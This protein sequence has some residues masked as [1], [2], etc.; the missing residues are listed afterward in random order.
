MGIYGI[1]AKYG[2]VREKKDEFLQNQCACIGW[3]VEQ[4]P[5]L[6]KMLQKIKIGDIIYI[7][8]M[9]GTTEKELIIKAIGVVTDDTIVERQGLGLGISVR[10]IWVGEKRTS[11]TEEMYKNN[12]FNNTLYEEFNPSVSSLILETLFPR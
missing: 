3:S 9:A 7:K 4:A 11:I 1:G 12:V 8:S 6:H 2:G 5:A 10:W